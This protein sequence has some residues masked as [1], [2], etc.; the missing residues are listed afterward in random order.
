MQKEYQLNA[1]MQLTLNLLGA[2]ISLLKQRHICEIFYLVKNADILFHE[3]THA[4]LHHHSEHC[5]D[6]IL[7]QNSIKSYI[8]T[9]YVLTK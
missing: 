6:I 9:D 7:R 4:Q 1:N 5:L 2:V 8:Y 3:Q